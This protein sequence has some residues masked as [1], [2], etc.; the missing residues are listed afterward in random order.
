M[1]LFKKSADIRQ[2]LNQLR[3]TDKKIGWV[4]TMGALHEGHL[5]LLESARTRK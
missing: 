5:S 1:I 2:Y 4:P 3:T